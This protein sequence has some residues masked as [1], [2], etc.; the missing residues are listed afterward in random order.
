MYTKEPQKTRVFVHGLYTIS[1]FVCVFDLPSG[2][3]I[4]AISG[5]DCSN[6]APVA[7]DP[8]VDHVASEEDAEAVV[9]VRITMEVCLA[10]GLIEHCDG[11]IEIPLSSLL[12]ILTGHFTFSVNISSEARNGSG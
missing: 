4:N 12:C 3:G 9:R 7:P 5:A 11:K 8:V 10:D 1:V 6:Y 2:V